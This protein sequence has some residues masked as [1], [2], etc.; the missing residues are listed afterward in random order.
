MFNSTVGIRPPLVTAIIPLYN[1]VRTLA[2][3]I[4]SV[5]RAGRDVPI[6]AVIVNDGSTDGSD[7]IA[8]ALADRHKWISYVSQGNQGSA[9]ARNRACKLAKSQILAF[10]NADDEWQPN[11]ARNLIDGFNIDPS[12]S[13][14]VNSWRRYTDG[15]RRLVRHFDVAPGIVSNHFLSMAWGDSY[16]APSATAFRKRHF[17]GTGGFVETLVDGQDSALWAE[18]ALCGRIWYTGRA[19]AVWHQDTSQ[20]PI[21]YARRNRQSKYENWLE[22]RI[23]MLAGTRPMGVALNGTILRHQMIENLICDC[24]V[25]GSMAAVMGIEWLRDARAETLE[26][27]GRT[28]LAEAIRK[29]IPGSK[30][31]TRLSHRG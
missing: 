9:N 3:A 7:R 15:K 19:G 8:E 11:H 4:K 12:I 22:A 21:D 13:L 23:E 2:R 10:L 18:A 30:P 20:I 29:T 25:N 28:D 24:E 27:W 17:R 26:K 16:A 31:L 1:K 5:E 14:V 6:E